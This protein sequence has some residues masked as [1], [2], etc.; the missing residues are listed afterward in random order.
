[1]PSPTGNLH[2]FLDHPGPIAFAHRGGGLEAPENTMVAFER[3]VKLGY[4]YLETDVRMTSDGVP[5][6]FHDETF[7]RV[8]DRR[9]VVAAT[10]WGEAQRARVSGQQIPRLDEL[11]GTWPDARV[12]IDIKEDRGVAP[13]VAVLRRTKALDRVCVGAFSDRR[14]ARFRRLAGNGVCTSA[15]PQSLA[16]LRLA[17]FGVP[18]PAPAGDCAQVPLSYRGIPV[19]D[20]RLVTAAHRRGLPVHAFTIDDEAGMEGMLELGVDGI[21][22]DRPTLLKEVLVRRGQW[23]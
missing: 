20:R 3:A 13:V 2:A 4:R 15:A 9:G 6:V 16:R 18:V 5:L 7:D 1:M 8:T 22:T 12:N 14:I 23:V 19:L 21:M 11:L 17:S 10:P